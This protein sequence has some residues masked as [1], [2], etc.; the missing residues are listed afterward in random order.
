MGNLSSLETLSASENVLEGSVPAVLG[1]LK[2]LT[3]LGIGGNKLSGTIP[4]TIYNLSSLT[5]FSFAVNQLHGN[6]PQDL[7]LRFPNLRRLEMWG[8]QFNG[9]IP[10]SLSNA[11]K[12]YFID[13][14]YN[15]FS[16]KVPTYFGGLEY[17]WLLNLDW[18][19]LGSGEPDDM[20]F[21]D[22]LV[23]C[24]ML[25]KMG[26]VGN[27]LG[28]ILPNSVGNLSTH[29]RYF[30]VGD[31]QISGDIPSGIGNLV[32][33]EILEMRYNQFEG[34]IP[35]EIGM[36]QKLQQLYLPNNL[37]SG[38]IPSS[39]GNLSLLSQLNLESNR[40]QETIPPSLGN[41]SNLILLNLSQNNLSGT[42]PKQLFRASSLSI[43][44]NLA[45]NRLG[46]PLP[47][48]VA[49]LKNLVELDVSENELSGEIP[50]SLSSCTDLV[51][52]YMEG[53]FFQGSIP[54]AFSSLR[55]IESFDLS[56]NNLSG[57][58]PTFFE[59]F[60]LKKLNL[61]FND[62]EGEVPTKGIFTN[63]S[64]ISVVGN[65][66]LC[67]GISKLQLPRCNIK[68]PRKRKLSLVHII[69][70]SV[71][72]TLLGV[73]M[74]S[75]FLFYWL[76]KKRRTQSSESL[77]KEPFLKVSYERLLKATD[78][79]SLENLI[80]MGSFGSVYKG[81]L[82]DEVIVAVKVLNLQRGGA[83]KS[84]MAECEALRNI[85]HRN[86]V[87]IITT[88]S[89]I[90][91][92]GNDFKALVYEFMP[93]GSL[94]RWLHSSS[95]SDNGQ[96]E[97]QTLN[98]HQRINVA[99]DVASALDYLH[100][101]CEKTII[102]CDLKPSNVLLDSDMVAHVGDF[103]L[104][105]YL[106]E[107]SNPSQSSSLGIRGT[108]GY[109]APECG[110]GSEVSTKGDVYSYGILLL[111]MMTGKRPTD[112]MFEGS[113]N[114]H[115]FASMAFPDRVMEILDPV[116][117]INDEATA[118]AAAAAA[119]VAKSNNNRSPGQARNDNRKEECLISMVK[120]GLA[121]S[122]ESPLDRMDI[123]NA[124]H[125]LLLV[126]DILQGTRTSS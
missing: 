86:L 49:S 92:Q 126:R 64:A 90:D 117:T 70:I 28:G 69:V 30:G 53:N 32:N 34:K 12:L 9:P 84:F 57:Q 119:A 88:C 54:P 58:I 29:L 103:G 115:N 14:S 48:E 93:N 81:I 16:G 113:L 13:L 59:K 65:N 101:H 112:N 82:Q 63:A 31:N 44:L 39:L 47:S 111:E 3:A 27:Q 62:F 25:D 104:A 4:S 10:I 110:M 21:L 18:N 37:L 60:S 116:L 42:I 5:V 85:R 24:S 77:L 66:K 80:G 43:S 68:K 1:E 114:L 56:R 124:I 26:V 121:C 105:R 55:G 91:F 78:G 108:I 123:S 33:I 23:N 94:E 99:I 8:N 46:G 11:S 106:P 61:S 75:S 2:N 52:L 20:N 22:S 71:A 100:N 76:R 73:A 45:R 95:E 120:I 97:P 51:N 87:K 50:S 89:S 15:N 36:I 122:M 118:A 7:G 79:F 83:S 109:A 102:H 72:C 67:G 125:E 35:D 38:K 17:L 19:I 74:V 40:L 96:D 6:L 107:L 98:L 41:C